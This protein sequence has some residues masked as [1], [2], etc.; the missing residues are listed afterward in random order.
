MH[1]LQDY[2]I[3][4]DIYDPWT[5]PDEARHEYGVNLVESPINGYYDGIVLAVAH[6]Q[7]KV[8]GSNG[9]RGFGKADHVL[10]DLKNVLGAQESD[11]RL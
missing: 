4:I 3:H 8:M 11:L 2:G 5:N 10:Y 9:M 7:F 1:E 6:D